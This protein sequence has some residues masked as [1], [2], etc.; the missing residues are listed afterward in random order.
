M[1]LIQVEITTTA[2]THR[3]GTLATGDILRTDAAFARHLVKEAN[4]AR[5]VNAADDVEPPKGLDA[6]AGGEA[7]GQAGGQAGGNS[8]PSDGL[9]VSE[10]IA[11]LEA[12]KIPI[13]DNAKKADLQALLDSAPQASE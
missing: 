4:C 3:Y 7:G 12:K 1:D 5:Y 9:K 2:H 10:L 6:A 8:K 11:A 13:P